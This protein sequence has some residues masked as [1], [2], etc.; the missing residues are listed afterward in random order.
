MHIFSFNEY[1]YICVIFKG[2]SSLRRQKK[3]KEEQGGVVTDRALL[4][5]F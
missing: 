3:G 4:L 5:E 2:I 1:I